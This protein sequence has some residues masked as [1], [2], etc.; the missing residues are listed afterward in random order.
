MIKTALV[1]GGTRGIGAAISKH[2]LK[3]GYKVAATF[4]RNQ[5]QAQKFE[6]ETGIKVYCWDVKDLKACEEGVRQIEKDLGPIDILVNNAGIT[7]DV[8]FH[9]MSSFQWNDVIDT[10]LSSCFNM[11]QAVIDGMRTRQYGRIINI[12]SIN[13]QQGQFGQ[14]NYAAAKA[15]I[16]GF[17]KSLAIETAQKG[18]TVNAVAPGYIKTEMVQ[19]VKPEMLDKI[20]ARIPVGRLGEPEDVAN[21]VSFLASEKTGFMTGAT[22]TLNGGQYLT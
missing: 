22:L 10:N 17:T 16:I 4:Q 14:T 7:S 21:A 3:E 19:A 15:G 6:R 5:T 2:L 11:C 9:K 1:T 13:G 18:I 20:I 8:S 12:S